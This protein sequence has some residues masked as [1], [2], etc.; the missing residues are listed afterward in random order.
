MHG[1]RRG[2]N[3]HKAKRSGGPQG[4]DVDR[5]VLVGV[6]GVQNKVLRPGHFLQRLGFAVVDKVVRAQRASLFFLGGR[7][8]KG[9]YLRAEDARKLDGHVSQSADAHNAHTRRGVDAMGAQRVINRDAAAQQRRGVFALQGIGDRYH[10]AD[11]GADAV[12]V[13]AVA[14]NA[15]PFC[16]GTEVFH[17]PRT[18]LALATGVRLPAQTNP[19]TNL[20]RRPRLRADC[21]NRAH[22]LMAGNEWILADA[23]VVRDQVKIAV[24]DAA[25]GNGDLYLLRVEPAR[26]IVKGQQFS[27][28]RM[29]CKSL[30]LSH[31]ESGI[32]AGGGKEAG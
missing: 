4:L 22:N 8:G 29:Y 6:G 13:A 5:P 21:H 16:G 23:P 25:V 11:I 14:V 19:L 3:A 12:R 17:A 10:E 27:A 24:A 32:L 26:L 20:E 15:G 30:N 18:P 31:N 7:G 1:D 28:S 2:R 9:R